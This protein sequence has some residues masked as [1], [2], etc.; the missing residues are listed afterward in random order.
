MASQAGIDDLSLTESFEGYAKELPDGSCVAY[1]DSIGGVWTAGFGS[2]Q[3]VNKD[4]HW[5]RPQA[6]AR[7]QSDWL[8]A[9]QGVLKASPILA[10]YKNRLDAVTDFA[11]NLGVSRYIGSSMRSY[12]NRQDWNAASLEFQKWNLGGGKVIAGL[13]R[14]RAAEQALFQTPDSPSVAVPVPQASEYVPSVPD[15]SGSPPAS[16]NQIGSLFANFGRQLLAIFR[17]NN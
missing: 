1:W 14:R 6:V 11:Y 15:S 8:K 17:N 12:I 10:N 13:V 9:R 2:T 7:I 16:N 4:T 3:G 5:T